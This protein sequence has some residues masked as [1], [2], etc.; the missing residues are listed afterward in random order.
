MFGVRT[1]PHT[2][3]S[4]GNVFTAVPLRREQDASAS[5]AGSGKAKVKDKDPRQTRMQGTCAQVQCVCT[6]TQKSR[7]FRLHFFDTGKKKVASAVGLFLFHSKYFSVLPKRLLI[8]GMDLSFC[9]YLE[10]SK[11]CVL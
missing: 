7:P 8:R 1:F 6:N 11:L 3:V 2:S 4:A 5:A 10:S 9:V